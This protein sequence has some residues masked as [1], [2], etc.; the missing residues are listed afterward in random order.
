MAIRENSAWDGVTTRD[1]Y[2]AEA[3]A[4]R[5]ALADAARDGSWSR[6]FELLDEQPEWANATRIGGPSGFAPL[7][8]AA[9]HGAPVVT[10]TRLLVAGAWRTLRTSDGRRASDIAAS[11]GHTHLLDVLRPVVRHPLPPALLAALEG[12]L[13]TLVRE[14]GHGLVEKHRLALPQL[15]VLTELT[16]PH[17]GFRIPGMY[18]GF[19]YRLEGESLIVESWSRVVGGSGRRHRVTADGATLIAEGFV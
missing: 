14:D 4:E 16:V 19:N 8:Q 7:H 5:D 18:G 13:H 17:M 2:G 9:W 12:H 15:E 10:A 6:V 11:R 1:V 3:V